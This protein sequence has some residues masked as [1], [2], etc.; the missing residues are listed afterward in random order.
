M[1]GVSLP[2]K[3]AISLMFPAVVFG[4]VLLP[5]Q[6]DKAHLVAGE[7]L[8]FWLITLVVWQWWDVSEQRRKDGRILKRFNSKEKI[9]ILTA[10]VFALTGTPFYFCR[11]TGLTWVAAIIIYG[12]TVLVSYGVWTA[13][14][15]YQ[16]RTVQDC[17]DRNA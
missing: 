11:W 14:D 10:L 17:M 9:G 8:A 16:E 1:D 4:V 5:N 13:W 6:L 7:A 2:G 15:E 12:L 3:V